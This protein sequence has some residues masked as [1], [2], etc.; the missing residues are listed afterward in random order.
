MESKKVFRSR[1]SVLLI[2]FTLSVFLPLLIISLQEKRYNDV[3]ML[4]GCILF[5]FL[6]FT[7]IKYVIEG[8]KILVKLWFIT[9]GTLKIK[10]IKAIQ[11]SYN[12]LS[13]P[14][15]SLKRVRIDFIKGM[16][17]LLS[18]V[19]EQVFIEELKAINPH[20]RINVPEKKGKWRIQDW[21]I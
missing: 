21:D 9:S 1:I 19:R 3:Y 7:G 13:S 11:R 18:P 17:W 8:D 16:Y 20:I 5:V 15:A 12:P 2:V 10:E 6:L 14:A 4:V